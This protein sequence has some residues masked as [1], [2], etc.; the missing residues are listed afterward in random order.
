M[1]L[2]Y[3]TLLFS[4]IFHTNTQDGIFLSSNNYDVQQVWVSDSK[5]NQRLVERND[6]VRLVGASSKL[7]T[8][9]NAYGYRKGNR[10]FRFWGK[11]SFEIINSEG[12]F[13]YRL[14][15]DSQTSSEL[16]Y[17]SKTSHDELI[18]LNRKNLKE[19]YKN[20]HPVFTE[21]VSLLDWYICLTDPIAPLGKLRVVELFQYCTK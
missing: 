7:F 17:F 12:I 8:S 15:I 16:Y 21:S 19:V 2:L 18:P 6:G 1:N 20:E 5:K 10:A 3:A 14:E 11:N 13:I 4:G 9:K